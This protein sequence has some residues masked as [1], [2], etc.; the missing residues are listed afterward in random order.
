MESIWQHSS[1]ILTMCLSGRQI[2][3]SAG[4]GEVTKM[5]I[6]KQD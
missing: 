6:F 5:F 1:G 3:L 2:A 4:Q